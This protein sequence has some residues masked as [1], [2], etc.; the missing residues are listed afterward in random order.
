MADSVQ[1]SCDLMVFGASGDLAQRK[2][3]PALYQLD[4]AG[5]LARDS[6]ILAIARTN[7]DEQELRAR[8]RKGLQE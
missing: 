3:F 7:I 4:R 8:L 2:L 5:L 6:R 1:T